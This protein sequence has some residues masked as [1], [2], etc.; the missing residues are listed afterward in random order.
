[1]N[2][3]ET[4]PGD[5][6]VDVPAGAP[7]APP[8]APWLDTGHDLPD[9]AALRRVYTGTPGATSLAKE[10]DHVHPLYRPYIEAS[11]F[12]VLATFGER[13]LDASPRGD[14][15]GFVQVADAHTLLLPDRPGNHRIDSLRNLVHDPRLALLFLIPGRGETLRVNG[16]ARISVAPA[17]LQRCAHE[18]KLPRSV[19]V[20]RVQTV[21]FQC[22]RALMRS[23]LWEPARWLSDE[24][25]AAV[26]S[27]GTVLGTLSR[28]GGG[29]CIDGAAYDAALRPRQRGSLY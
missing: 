5:A 2:T 9:L 15:A 26:P 11:P 28:E 17:L 22:A 20:V 3:T 27:A 12:V 25:L 7:P 16:R 4:V 23:G 8:A 19:I 13:G 1:M 10:A 29:E 14:P 21:F 18:G 6:P 24:A